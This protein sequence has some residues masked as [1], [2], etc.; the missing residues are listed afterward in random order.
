MKRM[1]RCTGI[2]KEITNLENQ[3]MQC[4]EDISQILLG[5]NDADAL[6]RKEITQIEKLKRQRA[7][8]ETK[9][10]KL[11]AQFDALTSEGA[12]Q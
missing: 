7:K 4:Y 1:N 11:Y 5:K 2:A 9:L 8:L 12:L 6:T 10:D 3:R